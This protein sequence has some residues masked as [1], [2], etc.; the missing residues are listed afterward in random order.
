MQRL[1]RSRGH[2]PRGGGLLAPSPLQVADTGTHMTKAKSGST[3]RPAEPRQGP[4]A[5]RP[6][7]E[8]GAPP[9]KRASLERQG[10]GPDAARVELAAGPVRLVGE[11]NH[12]PAG[13]LALG[14]CVT[15]ILLGAAAI[16]WVS[17]SVG[18]RHPWATAFA[19]RRR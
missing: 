2:D 6:Q 8:S 19:L 13:L 14:A 15:S 5:A 10:L 18:R 9:P 12:T 7:E 17:T 3:A 1:G 11:V 16:V 4:A